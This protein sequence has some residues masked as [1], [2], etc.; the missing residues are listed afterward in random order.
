M[1]RIYTFILAICLLT[2]QAQA[3][4][5][6]TG[7]EE[8]CVLD[9]E[10][11]NSD[12]GGITK[13]EHKENLI[14]ERIHLAIGDA[15]LNTIEPV[16]YVCYDNMTDYVLTEF[17]GKV[18]AFY[19]RTTP[20]GEYFLSKIDMTYV[21]EEKFRAMMTPDTLTSTDMFWEK[22]ALSEPTLEEQQTMQVRPVDGNGV[23]MV[24]YFNQGAGYYLGNGEWTCTDWPDATFNVNGH[25]MHAAGCGFFSTAMALSYLKQTIISPVEFK[26]NGQYISGSGSAVTIGIATAESYGVHAYFTSDINDV[27]EALKN[28]HPVLA[29]VGP[30][31]FTDNGHYILLVGYVNG[32]FAV[33]DPGHCSN[34]YFYNGT[35]WDQDTIMNAVLGRDLETAFTIFD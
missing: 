9:L 12:S 26:E 8:I 28:G 6:V 2:T 23:M 32:L 10:E 18:F 29:H 20:N 22:V 35:L 21:P 30:S 17:N 13:L 24:P 3:M 34:T 7:E 33:N 1:K 19:V 16:H 14:R 15:W 4:D 27:I 25:T 31:V 11:S 5:V